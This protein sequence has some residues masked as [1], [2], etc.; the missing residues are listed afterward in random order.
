M[1]DA[2]ELRAVLDEREIRDV[3][4]RYCRG[5][6]RMDAA[7]V[8]S[9]YHPD[10]VDDHGSFSGDVE[11]FLAWVW[12]LLRR[13]TMTMHF[14]GNLLVEVDGDVAA[15]ES[16]GIAFHRSD[17]GRPNLN[18]ITGFRFLDR[19]E[20][21]QGSWRIAR[22]TAVTEWSRVD[23]EAGRFLPGDSQPRGRRDAEDTSYALFA[24]LG[25]GAAKRR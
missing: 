16:Y 15:A 10:A 9:C 12:P 13:Y 23:D 7:L 6:D 8:R 14:V 18:L 2:E 20:R 3:I 5:I 22:R 21:R 19:F 11:A 4:L 25:S 17:A 24:D 1:A